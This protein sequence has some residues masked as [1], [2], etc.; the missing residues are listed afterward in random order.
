M[1]CM[2]S[3]LTS[4]TGI[5]PK[6]PR[7]RLKTIVETLTIQTAHGVTLTLMEIGSTV[8]YLTALVGWILWSRGLLGLVAAL[9]S[10]SG[11]EVRAKIRVAE[12][13]VRSR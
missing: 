12:I 5:S 8:T 1:N 7:R 4:A 10:Q 9:K 3:H 13:R 11:A 2:R 6:V